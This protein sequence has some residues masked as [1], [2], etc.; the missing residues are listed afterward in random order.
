VFWLAVL[1]SCLGYAE[2]E[3]QLKAAFI[4][5]FTKYVTWPAAAEQ[6]G[7]TLHV[8][9]LGRTAYTPELSRLDGRTVRNFTLQVRAVDRS[10]EL[11]SCNVLYLSGASRDFSSFKSLLK[12]VKGEPVLTISDDSGFI[13]AGGVIGLFTEQRRIR[14]DIN[15]GIARDT[16]LYISS[17]LLQLARK[18]E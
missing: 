17:R 1:V 8:C 3:A 18:V 15:L 4:Y 16:G 7:G 11:T 6:A 10:D 2:E 9:A 13:D 5:N 12:G 14:F